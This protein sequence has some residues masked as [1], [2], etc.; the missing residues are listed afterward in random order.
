M[1]AKQLRSKIV[2]AGCNHC[3]R[4]G[5]HL[6]TEQVGVFE[7]GQFYVAIL[8]HQNVRGIQLSAHYFLLVQ[9]A[10]GIAALCDVGLGAIFRKAECCVVSLQLVE[11][12]TAVHVRHGYD[13]LVASLIRIE[14]LNDEARC[15]RAHDFFHQVHLLRQIILIQVV[16]PHALE[17]H[18]LIVGVL[19]VLHEENVAI[20]SLV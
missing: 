2:T 8:V 16:F 6:P 17:H 7:V 20:L 13:I 14:L 1:L 11:Q 5:I 18:W 19:L 4:S 15:G 3:L 12:V 10:D 9:I